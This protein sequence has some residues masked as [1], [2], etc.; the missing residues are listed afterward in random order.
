MR[1]GLSL[2]ELLIA[3][4][5]MVMIV[6]AMSMLAMAV[7]SANDHCQGQSAAAQHGRV[8]LDRVAH[9]VSGAQASEQFPGCLVV[10]TTVGTWEFPD[11]LFVWLPEGPATDPSG[12][13][14]VSELVLFTPD[15][16]APHCLLEIRLPGNTSAAPAVTNT[17]GWRALAAAM[18]ANQ[19]AERITLTDRLRTGSAVHTAGQ[20]STTSLR[21]CVRFNLLMAPSV[22]D[23]DDYRDGSL[24][25]DEIDWPLDAYSSS[26]GSRRVVCQTELQIVTDE[27]NSAS[28]AVPFFG[29]AGLTYSLDR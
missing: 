24:A 27:T 15:A 22:A 12:L 19:A 16:D 29:A 11:T 4:T 20:L 17:S 23:W 2:A 25:W 28:T 14:R 6:G 3:S 26:A 21:G 5:I 1:R 9:A 13:P 7:H 8:A 18:R 10:T